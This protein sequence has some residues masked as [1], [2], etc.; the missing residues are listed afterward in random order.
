[1]C[2]VHFPCRVWPSEEHPCPV[3]EGAWGGE[4]DPG[5]P[6]LSCALPLQRRQ[7]GAMLT[8]LGGTF[9]PSR[10]LAEPSKALCAHSLPVGGSLFSAERFNGLRGCSCSLYKCPVSCTFV[11]VSGASWGS[12]A[13]WFPHIL[14]S[15]V[16]SQFT[17]CL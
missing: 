9:G 5:Q 3:P 2:S 4:V 7:L 15:I 13:P 6:E 11:L 16:L 14:C 12:V 17:V 8:Q 1:M 10:P